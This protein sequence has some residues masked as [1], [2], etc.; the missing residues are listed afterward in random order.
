M[1]GNINIMGIQPELLVG[2]LFCE[3]EAETEV[4]ATESDGITGIK[5]L[6]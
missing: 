6:S 3:G 5:E 2:R 4:E 1:D